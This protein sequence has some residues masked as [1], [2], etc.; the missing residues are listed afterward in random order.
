MSLSVT[1]ED[2]AFV[3]GAY[4]AHV[5]QGSTLT[6]PLDVEEQDPTS[7]QQTSLETAEPVSC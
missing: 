6:Q 2:D 3:F 5:K 1:S 4:A 7:D